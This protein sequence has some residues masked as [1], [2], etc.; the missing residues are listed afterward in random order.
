MLLQ[1]AEK[2]RLSEASDK[3]NSLDIK[4]FVLQ[5]VSTVSVQ[6][7]YGLE[8]LDATHGHLL[9]EDRPNKG[10]SCRYIF[11]LSNGL[12]QAMIFTLKKNSI[13]EDLFQIDPAG[14]DLR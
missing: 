5:T 2:D 4:K 13:G 7:R 9:S 11:E 1:Q 14:P 12:S 8:I 6:K 10:F 3:C